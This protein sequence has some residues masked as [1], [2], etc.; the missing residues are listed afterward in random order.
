[1]ELPVT[2]K[3]NRCPTIFPTPDQKAVQIAQLLVEEVL[4]VFGVPEVLL[5]DRGTNLLSEDPQIQVHQS[6]I[7]HCPPSFPAGF[8]WYGCKK[9]KSGRPPRHIILD[10]FTALAA[11][12][13]KSTK[14]GKAETALQRIKKT[15]IK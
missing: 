2:F 9:N 3:G 1:V 7:Q 6:R 8:Y 10:H 4:P 14:L 11:D 13:N 12:M 15:V 5:S